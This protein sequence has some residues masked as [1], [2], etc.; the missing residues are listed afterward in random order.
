MSKLFYQSIRSGRFIPGRTRFRKLLSLVTLLALVVRLITLFNDDPI[1]L[2]YDEVDYY[3]LGLNLYEGKGFV[4]HDS[5]QKQF[6]GGNTGEPTAYR[7]VILPAF[8]AT[9]FFI[10]GNNTLPPRIT[11]VLLSALCCMVIGLTANILHSS[12]AGIIAAL[13]WALYP[14]A[15]LSWFS[16][17]RLLT[18]SLG[19]FFLVCSIYFIVKIFRKYSFWPT[20]IAGV[21]FGFAVLTRGYLA[22]TIP[23]IAGYLL[24][25]AMHRKFYAAFVFGLFASIVVSG[26]MVRNYF[27]LGKPVLSTQTDS[28]YWGNNEW[29]RGSVYGDIFSAKPWTAAQVQPLLKKYPG[30]QQFSEL[31]L[32]EVWTREGMNYAKTHPLRTLWLWGRKTVIYLLPLQMKLKGGIAFHFMY[33]LCGIGTFIAFFKMKRRKEYFL[34]LLPFIGAWFACLLTIAMDRY[35][36][37]TEPLLI[38]LGVI[39]FLEF[40]TGI[41]KR[42]KLIFTTRRASMSS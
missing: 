29:T 21:L 30:I 26:W 6:Q 23:L 24:F 12:T 13:V 28:F 5:T 4:S 17:D 42:S 40:Y 8:L 7:S 39:G 9:H 31:Q 32:S 20:A 34:L 18:E 41:R 38:I 14:P 35:R 27:A 3:K 22:L 2:R 25:F 11:L 16:A 37:T 10:F 1:E 36:Y 33:L 19:I 15:F